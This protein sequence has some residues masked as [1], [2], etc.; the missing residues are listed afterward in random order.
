MC[1]AVTLGFMYPAGCWLF[2]FMAMMV[3]LQRVMF[4]AHYPSD[5]M[6]GAAL[7]WLVASL[8]I[9]RL[10]VFRGELGRGGLLK[11]GI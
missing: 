5:V 4:Q 6:G 8:G 1:L 7:G 11:P 3:G 9:A 2:I 10:K